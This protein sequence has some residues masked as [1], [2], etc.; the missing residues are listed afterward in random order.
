LADEA[1]VVYGDVMRKP[2]PCEGDL[3]TPHD[4]SEDEPVLDGA[5]GVTMRPWSILWACVFG[6]RRVGEQCLE[7]RGCDDDEDAEV[8]VACCGDSISRDA[9]EDLAKSFAILMRIGMTDKNDPGL[10]QRRVW[11]ARFAELSKRQDASERE[12]SS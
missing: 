2:N 1:D 9:P 5:C 3:A 4:V 12:R 6:V 10:R 7:E 11:M 8:V